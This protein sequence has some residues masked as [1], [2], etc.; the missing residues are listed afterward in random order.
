MNIKYSTKALENLAFFFIKVLIVVLLLSLL[1]ESFRSIEVKWP[2]NYK[3]NIFMIS[4][5]KNPNLLYK[6]S[7]N[8]EKDG[9]IEAAILDIQAA[10]GILETQNIVNGP[11]YS[12]YNKRLE[13]LQK[14]K[15]PPK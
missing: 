7:E 14:F 1:V 10:I 4:L 5:I 2:K 3:A 11:T 15:L 12:K 6:L 8:D 13:E 9:N